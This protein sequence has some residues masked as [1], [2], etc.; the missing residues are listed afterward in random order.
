MKATHPYLT[1][2]A[3]MLFAGCGS[4]GP[5]NPG[6][7]PNLPLEE[8][9]SFDIETFPSA[10]PATTGA[11]S[12]PLLAAGTNYAAAAVGLV[13]INVAVITI[14]SVPRVT[15]AALASQQPTF[16]NGEWHWRN[17]T[18]ILGVTYSGDLA[19]YLAEGDLV[20]EVRISSPVVSDFLWYDV[21]APIGGNS[22]Q[23]RIY[24]P[25]QPTTPTVVGTIDWSHPSSDVWNL[26]FTAVGGANPGDN[27][28]YMVDGDTRTVGWYDASVPATYG[29]GW[30]AVTHA[31]YIQAA[32][33]NGGVKSCWDGTLQDVACS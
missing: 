22:G 30:D 4:T 2:A 3:G 10:P 31:G 18:Q 27:L 21:H 7:P 15:W 12:A 19:A 32:G 29:I 23:W 5:G 8:A 1:L 16:E 25:D 11:A 13:G 33:W 6:D 9:I 24:S 20:A 26:T 28:S 17:S 14:T